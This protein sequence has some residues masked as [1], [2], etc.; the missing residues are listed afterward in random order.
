MKKP[1]CKM[2]DDERTK[3][4]SYSLIVWFT[5]GFYKDTEGGPN[6]RM[7]FSDRKEA[8][9]A[10]NYWARKRKAHRTSLYNYKTKNEKEI[11]WFER[12]DGTLYNP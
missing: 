6:M 8:T 1:I 3:E 4:F 11:L 10:F 7:R 9:R 12:E 5:E 2:S